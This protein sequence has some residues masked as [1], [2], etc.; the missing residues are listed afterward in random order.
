MTPEPSQP[1]DEDEIRRPHGPVGPDSPPG[2][3]DARFTL[4]AERTVLAWIRTALG[5]LAGGL[6]VVYLAPATQHPL[7]QA[8]VGGLLV[9]VGC[10]IALLGGRRWLRTSRALRE[11]GELPGTGPVLWVIGAIVV[12]AV[13]MLAMIIVET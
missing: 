9:T 6:A 1:S 12:L 2:S 11:G 10:I 8:T 3:V 13:L 4:A 7:W 5:F